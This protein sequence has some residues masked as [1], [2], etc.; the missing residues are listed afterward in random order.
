MNVGNETF[1]KIASTG[2]LANFTVYLVSHFQMKQ[3]DA[4][5]LAQIFFGTTNF[6]PLVG[7]FV[8]DT[9]LG[10]FKTLACAS[11][12]SFLVLR[13]LPLLI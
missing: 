1:E 2:L 9:C 3:V 13:L 7:A 5:N 8:A 12:A 4:A 10:R 6:A 11:I